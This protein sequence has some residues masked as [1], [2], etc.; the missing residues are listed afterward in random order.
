MGNVF[1]FTFELAPTLHPAESNENDL[2]RDRI[3]AGQCPRCGQ[4]TYRKAQCGMRW[5]PLD[6]ESVNNGRCLLCYPGG[7]AD[8]LYNTENTPPASV[9]ISKHSCSEEAC[10]LCLLLA[11][12]IGVMLYEHGGYYE[13][14]IFYFKGVGAACTENS[15]CLSAC[16]SYNSSDLFG[17]YFECKLFSNNTNCTDW[18]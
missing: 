5:I 4:Q 13:Y 14:E 7:D 8:A 6:L 2:G 12:I 11:I 15:E 18:G 9:G 3:R 10:L 17:E 1:G 16:C